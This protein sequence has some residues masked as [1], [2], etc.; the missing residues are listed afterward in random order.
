MYAQCLPVL[1]CCD[2]LR[3]TFDKQ[4]V[5]KIET[6]AHTEIEATKTCEFPRSQQQRNMWL[7]PFTSIS[8]VGHDLLA[9]GYR[10]ARRSV[11]SP[12]LS[13]F[14]ANSLVATED[15][16]ET[17][18]LN[19]YILVVDH[20][21]TTSK[22]ITNSPTYSFLLTTIATLTAFRRKLSK[23]PINCFKRTE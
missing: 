2:L 23:T 3:S 22:L 21:Q 19:R 20:H 17:E 7:Y 10:L 15:Y 12:T 16:Y 13:H 5:R 8:A 11:I 18:T 14:L 4:T 1:L 9:H 6:T